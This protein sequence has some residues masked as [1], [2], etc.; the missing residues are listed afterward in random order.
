MAAREP[1]AEPLPGDPGMPQAQRLAGKVAIVTGAGSRPAGP[2]G[3]RITAI[4]RELP[5]Y[6]RYDLVITRPGRRGQHPHGAGGIGLDR[7]GASPGLGHLAYA[8]ECHQ[9]FPLSRTFLIQI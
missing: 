6:T 7:G 3:P 2:D 1:R 4:D 9:V 8:G 5:S